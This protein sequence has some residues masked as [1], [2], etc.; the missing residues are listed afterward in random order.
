MKDQERIIKWINNILDGLSKLDGHKGVEIL[1]TCGIECSKASTLLEGA[2]K[3]QNEYRGKG[4]IENLFEAY[5]SK[6]YNTSRLTKEGNKITLI[7]EQCTCPMVKRGV[8]DSHLCNCTIGY[9]K[10]IFETLFDRPVQVKLL[11]SILKGDRICKQEI[12]VEEI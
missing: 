1:Q 6:Y 5:K 4:N 10:E 9:S 8:D 7:F 2:K 3:I 11:K 12:L